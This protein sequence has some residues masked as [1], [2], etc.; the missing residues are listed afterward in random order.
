MILVTD[1]QEYSSNNLENSEVLELETR[2]Q[3]TSLLTYELQPPLN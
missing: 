3:T 1:W 2:E